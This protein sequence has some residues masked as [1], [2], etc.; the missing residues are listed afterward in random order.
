MLFFNTSWYET[1]GRD[2]RKLN[3]IKQFN[4]VTTTTK[5]DRDFSSSIIQLLVTFQTPTKQMKWCYQYVSGTSLERTDFRDSL[6]NVANVFLLDFG[7]MSNKQQAHLL[8]HSKLYWYLAIAK[9]E[10]HRKRVSACIW[11]ITIPF[12]T[13]WYINLA[14]IRLIISARRH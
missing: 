8:S 13:R 2:R 10:K 6:P 14:Q 9:Y 7:G 1:T 12:I 5:H 11:Q 3:Y 4:V